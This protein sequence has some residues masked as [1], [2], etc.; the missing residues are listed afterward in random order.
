MAWNRL[1]RFVGDDNQV[2]YGEPIIS[3]ASEVTTLLDEG[4]LSAKELAGTSPFD[5]KETG[6]ELKVQ[7]LL[8]P[9]VPADVPI[10]RCV[11]LNYMKHSKCAG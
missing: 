11:G 5:C 7:K 6:K 9:L 4:K 1:I 10:V 2:H 8:G 3:S